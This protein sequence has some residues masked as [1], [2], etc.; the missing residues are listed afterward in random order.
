MFNYN[1]PALKLLHKALVCKAQ[2]GIKE[3][4]HFLFCQY[5][6][7]FYNQTWLER[8]AEPIG[9]SRSTILWST[10]VSIGSIGAILGT[11]LVPTLVLAL[12]R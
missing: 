1:M 9:V 8:Y 4:Y 3:L 12:G 5:V 6:Q 10:T 11:L 2:A 7:D